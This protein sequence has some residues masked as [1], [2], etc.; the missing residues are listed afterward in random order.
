MLFIQANRSV[1]VCRNIQISRNEE[2]HSSKASI[3]E[4]DAVVQLKSVEVAQR[5]ALNNEN[6][7]PHV[8]QCP[9]DQGL[10]Y[11][12]SPDIPACPRS[13][14]CLGSIGRKP[15]VIPMSMLV[16]GSLLLFFRGRGLRSSIH[17]FFEQHFFIRSKLYL[18]ALTPKY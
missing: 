12:F 18:P 11:A 5:L 4:R 10:P 2:L 1:G 15:P 8:S 3:L 16:I 13:I 6:D 14:L 17:L 7:C 9:A